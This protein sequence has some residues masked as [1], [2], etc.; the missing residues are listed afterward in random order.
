MYDDDESFIDYLILNG[1][2]EV[3]GVED[4]T[5]EILYGFTDKLIDV[6]PKLHSKF[7]SHFHGDMMH[8]WENGFVAMDVTELN[9]LVTVT[10]KAFDEIAVA[11]LDENQRETLLSII[12]K[13]ME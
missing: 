11:T 6:D 5:G 3:V 8:L 2:L 12:K 1:A 13:M 9:P 4:G 10:E 7:I